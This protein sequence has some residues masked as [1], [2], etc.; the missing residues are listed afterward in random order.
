MSVSLCGLVV[1]MSTG[2][3][4]LGLL[5]RQLLGARRPCTKAKSTFEALGAP[6]EA[7][8]GEF[9]KARNSRLSGDPVLGDRFGVVKP[10]HDFFF[11]RR[12]DE[13][14]PTPKLE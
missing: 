10:K 2:A 5:P 7:T 12:F 14:A 13:R 4:E 8:P 11:F 6:L 9:V 3:W 1:K